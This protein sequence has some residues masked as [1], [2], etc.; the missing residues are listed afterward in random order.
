[1][2]QSTEEEKKGQDGKSSGS[3]QKN[4]TGD[5]QVE[6]NDSP[7]IPDRGVRSNIRGLSSG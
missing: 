4:K 3:R 5:S 1:M 6:S 7:E 2:S